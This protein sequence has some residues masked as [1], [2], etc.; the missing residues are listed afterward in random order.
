LSAQKLS[1]TLVETTSTDIGTSGETSTHRQIRMELLLSQA[2]DDTLKM[3]GLRTSSLVYEYLKKR[4]GLA[5]D[6]ILDNPE[7]FSKGLSNLFGSASKS[8]EMRV[9]GKFFTLLGVKF[10]CLE[11]FSFTDY[12]A[13]LKAVT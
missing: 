8:I 2:I 9:V 10:E 13:A 12:I 5:R 3:L 4:H 6:E 7:T 1:S 11:G